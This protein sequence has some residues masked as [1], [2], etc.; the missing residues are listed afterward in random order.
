[1]SFAKCIITG[2]DLYIADEG[3]VLHGDLFDAGTVWIFDGTGCEWEHTW[4]SSEDDKAL[5]VL[6]VDYFE[7]NKVVVVTKQGCRLT[8]A[9][10]EYL[11]PKINL[12]HT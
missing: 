4:N 2:C 3:K 12:R 7:K 11:E 9:A 5:R 8:E 10:K 1:M 6:G